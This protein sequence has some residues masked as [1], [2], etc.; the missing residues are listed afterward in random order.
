MR[1]QRVIHVHLTADEGV[2][3]ESQHP[4]GQPKNAGE[5]AKAGAGA[6]ATQA[7]KGG[8]LHLHVHAPEPASEAPGGPG[9]RP[10][11]SPTSGGSHQGPPPQASGH[12]PMGQQSKAPPYHAPEH[13]GGEEFSPAAQWKKDYDPSVTQEGVY[14]AMHLS[15]ERHAE[16]QDIEKKARAQPQTIEKHR[17]KDGTYDPL[18]EALHDDILYKG[19]W[20][21]DEDDYSKKKWYP[22]LLDKAQAVKALPPKGQKPT[23]IMLA[24]RGGSGKTKLKGRVYDEAHALVLDSDKIKHMLPEFAGWNAGEVHEESSDILDAALAAARE[25]GYNVVLDATLKSLPNAEAKMDAFEKAGYCTEGHEMYL[26]AAKA[27]TRSVGRYFSPGEKAGADPKARGRFVTPDIILGNVN[28]EKN[29][30]ALRP[31]WQHWSFWS[32][33]VPMGQDPQLMARGGTPCM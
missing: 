23:F 20:G 26:P 24:G 21:A 16:M 18:R 11:P 29:F 28:N 25:Q 22:P 30:E 17:A 6:G 27:A 4:R 12:L 33:D 7:G 3:V 15:P 5:F 1:R 8:A 9:E 19:V 13:V 2:W 10:S 14:K 31:R 32:N